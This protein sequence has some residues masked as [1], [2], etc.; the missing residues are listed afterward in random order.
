MVT[1]HCCSDFIPG[2]ADVLFSGKTEEG[3]EEYNGDDVDD[4]SDQY[5]PSNMVTIEEGMISSLAMK[6]M[7]RLHVLSVMLSPRMCT[8]RCR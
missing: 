8:K 4:E 3:T 6:W 7:H 2:S 1:G 5:V